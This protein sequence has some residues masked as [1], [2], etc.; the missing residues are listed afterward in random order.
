MRVRGRPLVYIIL[1]SGLNRRMEAEQV[2]IVALC[3][4]AADRLLGAM[5][6]ATIV[7]AY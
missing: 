3:V 6:K 4:I 7:V 2:V 5:F 1:G